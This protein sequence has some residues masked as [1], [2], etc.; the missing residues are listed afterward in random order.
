MQTV[1]S[2]MG[3]GHVC[4]LAGLLPPLRGSDEAVSDG[5]GGSLSNAGCLLS[6]AS[7]DGVRGEFRR[8]EFSRTAGVLIGERLRRP[9]AAAVTASSSV[10]STPSSEVVRD[11]ESPSSEHPRD[12]G[13][14]AMSKLG[15]ELESSEGRRGAGPASGKQGSC[16]LAVGWKFRM[17]FAC[18]FGGGMPYGSKRC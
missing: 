2:G 13:S 9:E 14:P 7:D 5:A 17:L 16:G 11:I 15:D 4:S 18:W 12:I 1:H 3:E 8:D 10:N 6:F